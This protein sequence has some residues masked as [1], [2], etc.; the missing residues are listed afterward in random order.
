MKLK[1]IVVVVLF[2]IGAVIAAAVPSQANIIGPKDWT[3]LGSCH[4]RGGLTAD[5]Y[6]KRGDAAPTEWH[7]VE[8][9]SYRNG[10]WRPWRYS[11]DKGAWHYAPPQYWVFHFRNKVTGPGHWVHAQWANW[12]TSSDDWIHKC[13]KWVW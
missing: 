1:H 11:T 9:Q 8:V 7:L 5:F 13:S 4:A 2:V 3:Y 12:Y 6:W 10:D